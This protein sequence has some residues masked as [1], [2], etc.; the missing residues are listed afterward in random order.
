MGPAALLD[1]CFGQ[2]MEDA[3]KGGLPKQ[4]YLVQKLC[5]FSSYFMRN[6]IAGEIISLTLYQTSKDATCLGGNLKLSNLE[7]FDLLPI[8]W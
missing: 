5:Q 2:V 7:L 4:W 3:R 1:N 6:L 8:W